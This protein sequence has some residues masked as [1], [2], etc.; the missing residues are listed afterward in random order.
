MFERNI[1]ITSVYTH[2]H[3][4]FILY[5]ADNFHRIIIEI[6]GLKLNSVPYL[7]QQTSTLR[8]FLN[9]KTN[10]PISLPINSISVSEA[11]SAVHLLVDL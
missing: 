5:K 4:R 1:P 7:R 10:Y 11:A 9:I 2:I 3:H 8:I 6:L